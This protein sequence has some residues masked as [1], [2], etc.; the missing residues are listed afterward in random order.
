VLDVDGDSDASSRT[1]VFYK[2]LLFLK[3]PRSIVFTCNRS[4]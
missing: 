2:T 1:D 3:G 4:L